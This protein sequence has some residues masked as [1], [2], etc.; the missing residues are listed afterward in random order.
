M[1]D[2]GLPIGQSRPVNRAKL[3][4]KSVTVPDDIR[5]RLT[6]AAGL[7]RFVPAGL[8]LEHA[9]SAPDEA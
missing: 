5:V 7:V 9:I 2:Y 3:V 8:R 1:P 6:R 4:C